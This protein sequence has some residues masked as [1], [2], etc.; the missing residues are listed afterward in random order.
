MHEPG[1]AIALLKGASAAAADVFRAILTR[2]PISRIDIA[3]LLGLSQAAVTKAV[4]PLLEVGLVS[5]ELELPRDGQPGRPA[6]PLMVVAD[7][8]VSIGVKVNADEIVGVATDL[9]TTVLAADRRPLPA[10]TPEATVDAIA[11]TVADLVAALGVAGSDG[12]APSG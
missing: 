3:R 10:T 1:A 11:A 5:D 2:G 4:G 6:N 8:L 7:A 12:C 9:R